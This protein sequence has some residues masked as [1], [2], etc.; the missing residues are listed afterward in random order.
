[1]IGIECRQLS[2]TNQGGFM[3]DQ[4][5]DNIDM[6]YVAERLLHGEDEDGRVQAITLTRI[7]RNSMEGMRDRLDSHSTPVAKK[8]RTVKVKPVVEVLPTKLTRVPPPS[9]SA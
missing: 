2:L 4:L 1:M 7:A 3:I 9:I 6:L 5:A 8:R